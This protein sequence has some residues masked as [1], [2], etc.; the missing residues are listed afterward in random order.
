MILVLFLWNG[1]L[2][3]YGEIALKSDFVR[4][5]Y[6][7]K[8][9][10]NISIG[11]RNEGLN[12]K[13]KHRWSRI[14][15]EIDDI[16]K[17]INI[18]SRIF[19]ISYF[20]PYIYVSLPQLEDFIFQ[21]CKNFLNGINT[22]AIRVR[23]SGQHNFTSKDLEAKLG[24]IVKEKTG[25]KVS[26]DNPERTIYIEVRDSECYIYFDKFSGL[27][28][29]PLGTSGRVVCLV[30]GGI[31]S[32]VATWLMMKRGCPVSILYA[33]M[34]DNAR[35]KKVIDVSRKISNW[36]LGET[37]NLYSYDHF[38]WLQNIMGRSGKYT[39]ILCKI[40]MYKV[41][42]Y[43]AKSL[44]A[45]AIVTGESLGQVASQTHDNL[46]VLSSFSEIPLI[47]PLISYDKEE[48][49]SLSKKLG[50]YEYAIYKDN[51]I[52]HNIDCWA[53]PKHVTTKA[54]PETTSKLLLELDFNNF[55]NECIKSIKVI[56]F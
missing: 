2:V 4:R 14:L 31:D 21:N 27:N 44:G 35:F 5:R 20:S 37:M 30:S 9:M 7:G 12:F 22:F 26:L 53:R 23:R 32:P 11:L 17:A 51:Y 13:I 43:L 40:M 39:C 25:L 55:I 1:I 24:A 48:I 50:L 29:V 34:N 28:G 45:W 46:M 49:I 16:D 15:V 33:D 36:H 19:G 56:N 52:S 42:A 6:V 3:A 41:A 18:L 8:L 10:K 54:D 38:K 47:R